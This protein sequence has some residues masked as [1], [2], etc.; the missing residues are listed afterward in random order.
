MKNSK[1]KNILRALVFA[2]AVVTLSFTNITPAAA[3][4]IKSS[5][6]TPSNSSSNPH[7][8]PR[9]PIIITPCVSWNG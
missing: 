5:E 2:I 8:H 6:Q 7:P 4:V 1:I 3:G 9:P